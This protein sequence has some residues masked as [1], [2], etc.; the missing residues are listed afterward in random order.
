[1]DL[2]NPW[3]LACICLGCALGGGIL[4]SIGWWIFGR[5]VERIEDPLRLS[6]FADALRNL[7]WAEPR[8]GES[9]DAVAAAVTELFRAEVSYYYNRRK[10]RRV[11]GRILRTLAFL[12]GSAGLLCPLIEAAG[13]PA[14]AKSGY[15]LLA[16]A[17]ACLAANRL[18]GGTHGHVRYVTAQYEIE[19]L[20]SGFAI[21]W[22]EWRRDHVAKVPEKGAAAQGFV[23]LRKLITEV[24]AVIQQETRAWGEALTT[25]ENE[26][27]ANLKAPADGQ[28]K[29]TA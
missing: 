24:Y 7:D 17:A 2:A 14:L 3:W 15:V 27:A 5:S 6:T 22:Q 11:L 26:L 18:V 12:I 23:L 13:G 20:L 21:D 29:G 1:M 4:A 28:K 10:G 25:A 8:A 19:R 16:A 9:L